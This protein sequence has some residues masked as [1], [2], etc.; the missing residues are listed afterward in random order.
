[1]NILHVTQRFLPAIGGVETHVF[2]VVKR[3]QTIGFKVKVFTSDMLQDEALIRMG[4]VKVN[5]INIRRFKAI[6]FLK[7]KGPIGVIMPKMFLSILS[8]SIDIVH[9]HSFGYFPT[10][11]SIEP[12][13]LKGSKLVITTHSD[14]DQK[15]SRYN[16]G[17]LPL[18][19]ADLIITLTYKEKEKFV[20]L[21]INQK[22]IRVLPN[23]VD[24]SKYRE[25]RNNEIQKLKEKYDING[26]VIL[27]VGRID[28][29][30]KG[31]DVLIKSMPIVKKK[32][33]NAKFIF[34]GPDWGSRSKLET[35]AKFLNV[36]PIFVGSVND[37]KLISFYHLAE[38]VVVPSKVEPFGIVLLEAMACKKPIVASNVGGIP[39]IIKD[40]ENGLLVPK[41]NPLKLAQAIIKLLKND[42]LS[43]TIA[44]N[45]FTHVKK[46]SWDIIVEQL[47]EI[48]Y[49][50]LGK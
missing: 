4:E 27:Y 44:N 32:F 17:L 31:C 16:L 26:P 46:Y 8:E 12:K 19:I 29:K 41:D 13:L 18:K 14:P 20:K 11:V 21:G 35:M 1:L 23:G 42:K 9:A 25:R 22:K 33:P 3:L 47:K 34:V 2:E 40:G 30:Q 39:E 24:I 7:W 43:N 28:I 5:G 10:F 48:Y 15:V 45:A 37:E 38:V 6:K 49:S 36:D 50:I